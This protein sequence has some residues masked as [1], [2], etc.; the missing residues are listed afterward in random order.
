MSNT[1]RFHLFYGFV[2]CILQ[3][4]YSWINYNY[5]ANVRNVAAPRARSAKH[6][7]KETHYRN[8]D[9]RDKML[10]STT[11]ALAYYILIAM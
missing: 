2:S 8:D 4:R 3:Y 9:S 1:Q 5:T 6:Y 10:H 7:F 11:T